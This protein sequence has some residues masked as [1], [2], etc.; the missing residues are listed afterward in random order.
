MGLNISTVRRTLAAVIAAVPRAL[1]VEKAAME[2]RHA[3]LSAEAKPFA[4]NEMRLISV[5]EHIIIKDM[6]QRMGA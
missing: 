3:Q 5:V 6:L 4:A 1:K 2:V